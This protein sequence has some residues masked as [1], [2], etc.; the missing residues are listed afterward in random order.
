MLRGIHSNLDGPSNNKGYQRG[1]GHQQLFDK[2]WNYIPSSLNPADIATRP[3]SPTQLINSAWLHGPDF[4]YREGL[5]DFVDPRDEPLPEELPDARTLVSAVQLTDPFHTITSRV[6]SWKRMIRVVGHVLS[7]LSKASKG[8]IATMSAETV[9]LRSHQNARYPFTSPK[10]SRD[11]IP[12]RLHPLGLFLD[13]L[14]YTSD[15]ADE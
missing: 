9:L 2:K 8:K 4:L 15:A 13:C 5:P 11:G 1:K 14:L 12:S 7:F 10:L 6:S 3:K